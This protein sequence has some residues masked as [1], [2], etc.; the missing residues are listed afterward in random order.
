MIQA[1]RDRL[2]QIINE[3]S[4]ITGRDMTLSTGAS[5]TFYFDCKKTTLN[6]EGLAILAEAYLEEIDR[7][8]EKVEAIGGLTLGADPIAAAVAMRAFQIGHSTINACIVRK[9]RKKHGTKSYIENEMPEGTPIVVV[10]DVITSG[11]STA[12][13]CDHLLSHNYK[14]VGIVALI[15]RE[16]GG[17]ENLESKYGCTVRSVFKKSDFPRIAESERVDPVAKTAVRA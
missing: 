13:A 5:S 17:K 4:L 12:K 9:E 10:D 3:K 16:A 6:G 2:W 1:N 15:D 11:S 14:I 8:P 7:F